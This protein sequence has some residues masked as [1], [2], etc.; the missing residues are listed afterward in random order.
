MWDKCRRVR[1]G[2]R[3]IDRYGLDKKIN[4]WSS[5]VTADC[6]RKPA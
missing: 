3:L 4:T 2:H 1:P 6:P 5:E